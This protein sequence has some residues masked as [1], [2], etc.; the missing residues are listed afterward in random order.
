MQDILGHMAF[1]YLWE[2]RCDDGPSHLLLSLQLNLNQNG[3]A[4][5]KKQTSTFSKINNVMEY[6]QP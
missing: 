3:T 5:V 6:K 2:E 4:T 1:I